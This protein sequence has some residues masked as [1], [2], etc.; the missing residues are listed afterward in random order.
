MK[1]HDATFRRVLNGR[2]HAVEIETFGLRGKVG[3]GFYGEL[4]VAEDLVVVRPCWRGKVDRL[5]GGT[6]VEAGEEEGAE[7]DGAGAGDCLEGYCLVEES[8]ARQELRQEG[9]LTRFSLIAGLSAPK[10]SFCAA[11][12]KSAR[13]AIGRYSWFRSGSFRSNSSALKNV[14]SASFHREFADCY[15]DGPF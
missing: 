4:D 2:P 6:G 10:M 11:E 14:S 7:V 1:K 9:F 8:V 15:M 3:V 13:P 5:G 12:V